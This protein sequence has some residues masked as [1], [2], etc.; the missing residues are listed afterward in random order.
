[1]QYAAGA[2]QVVLLAFQPPATASASCPTPKSAAWCWQGGEV[3]L[4]VR[5]QGCNLAG[6]ADQWEL[7]GEVGHRS[8]RNLL[9]GWRLPRAGGTDFMVSVGGGTARLHCPGW[10]LQQHAGVGHSRFKGRLL[11]LLYSVHHL[12]QHQLVALK[13]TWLSQGSGARAGVQ[14]AVRGVPHTGQGTHAQ[15]LWQG[16]LI[17]VV[18]ALQP[19]L[20]WL[21]SAHAHDLKYKLLLG[22][23][24]C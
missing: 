2:R 17:A 24:N 3:S 9:A 4:E 11:V 8:S 6:I 10:C 1:M 18:E 16:Q 14:A 7:S 13:Y 5:A 20:L 21:A 23:T 19:Q 15:H 12:Y 22:M